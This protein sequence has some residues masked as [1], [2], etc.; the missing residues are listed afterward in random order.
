VEQLKENLG[1]LDLL[2]RLT[3]LV[4]RELD[5]ISAPIAD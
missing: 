1:A 5:D 4:M 2:D 3:P